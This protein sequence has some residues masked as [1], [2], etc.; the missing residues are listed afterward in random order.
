MKSGKNLGDMEMKYIFVHGLGQNASSWDKTKECLADK[1]D[2]V[3]PV[4]TV[5]YTLHFV[6]TVMPFQIRFIFADSRLA[7]FLL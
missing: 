3:I 4:L 6:N 5:K 7:Q 2:M 1:L